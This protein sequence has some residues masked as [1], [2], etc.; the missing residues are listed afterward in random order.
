MRT[1]WTDILPGSN[2]VVQSYREVQDRFGDS[3]GL[4]VVIEGSYADITAMAV[5]LTPQLRALTSLTSV[6]GKLPTEFTKDHG[7]VLTEQKDLERMLRIY[8]HPSMIGVLRGFNDDLEQEYTDNEK[9]LRNDELDVAR[10]ILGL[11]TTLDNLSASL[12]QDGTS[13]KIHIA[14]DAMTFGEPWMV[15]LDRKM[16]LIQC[17]PVAS[18]LEIDSLLA[19]V[20]EVRT[21]VADVSS[22]FPDVDA[23][24]TGIAKIM[25]DEM[26]SIG[27]YT[28]IL[29]LVALLLIF[30]ILARSF[31]SMMIPIIALAPLLVGIIWIMGALYLLFGGLNLFTAMIMIVLLGLGIDFTIHMISRFNEEI[32]AGHDLQSALQLML[33][34]TGMAVITGGL[35]TSA[36]FFALMIGETRGVFEFGVAAG[37]GVLLTLIAVYLTLPSLLVLNYRSIMRKKSRTKT[38]TINTATPFI[39][40]IAKAGYNKPSMF[41]IPAVIVSGLSIWAKSHIE[42]EYD[43]M[44]LE[45]KGLKSIQLQREIPK[46]FG[47]TD[48]SAWL[49][50]DSVEEARRLKDQLEDQST[51]GDVV[52]ISDFIPP[53]GRISSYERR[54]QEFAYSL[55][56]QNSSLNHKTDSNSLRI[57]LNRLWD[58]LD[59]M[60]NLAFTA[61]LDRVVNV[62]DGITGTDS[63]TGDVQK[64]ATLPFLITRLESGVESAR[65]DSIGNIWQNRLRT[66]LISMTSTDPIEIND[67]PDEIKSSLLPRVGDGYLMHIFP[68]NYLFSKDD[69]DRFTDQTSSVSTNIAGTE[70]LITVMFDSILHD[71]RNAAVLAIGI[72]ILL[73][74]IQFKHPIGLLSLIPLTGGALL[75]IGLMYLFGEKYNYMNLIA[76]PIIL[77]IGIDDGIHAMHR[78]LNDKGTRSERIERSFSTVGRAILL[79]SLTTMIGFGS[80]AFY[81]ME[82]M[83]SFGRALFLGVGSCFAAT[84]LLLPAVLRLF[85]KDERSNGIT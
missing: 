14:A 79:T 41:I 16:L 76:V 39:G 45:P 38:L 33:T 3:G 26:S 53:P 31:R 56:T 10:S 12:W 77:G 11:H 60:S 22:Q 32:C 27:A 46:R 13:E 44:N 83:A 30:V 9:N 34:D 78:F 7:F 24:L 8:E 19:T 80:V 65:L 2:P 47:M 42:F 29:S 82:G 64:D 59:L 1:N 71:G 52:A 37:G 50:T 6:Q 49:V 66:N 21:L 25:E 75:M 74:L 23:N 73:V 72:I 54:L 51:V 18:Q 85:T 63:E 61:G 57:E 5:E 70:R 68:R 17:E 35:T 43:F 40:R 4:V 48:H 15:S 67:L 28:I 69:L 81:T 20:A 58:N 36:A 55:T 62:I 84:V